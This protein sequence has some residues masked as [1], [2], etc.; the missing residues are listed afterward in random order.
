MPIYSFRCN[1]CGTTFDLLLGVNKE[2]E[3]MRCKKCASTDIIRCFG[4]FSVGTARSKTA[5]FPTA[6]CPPSGC[7]TGSC[8]GCPATFQ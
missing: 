1:A 7:P 5:S 3:A 2:G 4:S 8:Q 6:S